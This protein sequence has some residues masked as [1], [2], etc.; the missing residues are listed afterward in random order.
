MIPV[1]KEDIL[2]SIYNKFQQFSMGT[3]YFSFYSVLKI[4]M[5]SMLDIMCYKVFQGSHNAY[6]Y[7]PTFFRAVPTWH[8][9]AI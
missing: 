5:S 3:G 4:I 8:Y 6:I 7:N 9:N 2:A 1:L